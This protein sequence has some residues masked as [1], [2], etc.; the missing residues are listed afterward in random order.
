MQFSEIVGQPGRYIVHQ[1]GVFLGEGWLLQ[2][3]AWKVHTKDGFIQCTVDLGSGQVYIWF[4]TTDL[5]YPE[6]FDGPPATHTFLVCAEEIMTDSGPKKL[7]KVVALQQEADSFV[8][9]RDQS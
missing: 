6:R 2:F 1:G 3:K 5:Y 8:L 9:C 4:D 7:L